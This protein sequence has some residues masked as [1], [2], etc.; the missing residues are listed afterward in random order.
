MPLNSN[1]TYT[2]PAPEFPAVPGTVI[3][4]AEF[5]FIILDMAGALSLA[6]FRNGLTPMRADVDMDGHD[7]RNVYDITGIHDLIGHHVR[8]ET[9]TLLL[10]GD[11]TVEDSISVPTAD[12]GDN[13]SKAAST[14]FVQAAAFQAVLP[15]QGPETE[16][17]TITS[18]G[19]EASWQDPAPDYWAAVLALG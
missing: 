6:Y 16:G 12:F 4:A 1:G 13:S 2:P 7:L 17:F 5:N 11:V 8:F 14:A 18:D 15:A 19:E 9:A 10:Q 3:R